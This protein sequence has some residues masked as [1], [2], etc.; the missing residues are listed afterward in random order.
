MGLFKDAF[1][2]GAGATLGNIAV[3]TGYEAASN[4][5]IAT[6]DKMYTKFRAEKF[7]PIIRQ[8][9]CDIL[10]RGALA[11]IDYPFPLNAS[12][13]RPNFFMRH[14]VFWII[15]VIV[16]WIYFHNVRNVMAHRIDS[17]IENAFEILMVLYVLYV[18]GYVA[19]ALVRKVLRGT[20][21]LM[22]ASSKAALVEEGKK[23]WNIREYVRQALQVGELS[24]E[25]AIVKISNTGLA[26]QFP[27]TVDQ[28]EANAFYYRQRLGL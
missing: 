4:F 23:Y 9:L 7:D 10:V 26:C 11:E 18:I 16:G 2:V 17:D 5:L 15:T 22:L 1:G 20:K 12:E 21:N 24:V 8:D 6:G 14:K 13:R 27:D 25:N 28:I 3:H 19:V